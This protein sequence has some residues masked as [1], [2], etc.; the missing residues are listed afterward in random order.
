MWG[1]LGIPGARRIWCQCDWAGGSDGGDG[2]EVEGVPGGVGVGSERSKRG[3]QAIAGVVAASGG[4]DGSKGRWTEGGRKVDR[5]L[6]RSVAKVAN[7]AGGDEPVPVPTT[8]PST[9]NTQHSLGT[10]DGEV[11][12]ARAR[13]N[14]RRHW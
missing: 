14:Y 1:V 9:R 7:L 11:V 2:G 8:E 5:R 3:P 4:A 13:V 12:A 6:R 10:V